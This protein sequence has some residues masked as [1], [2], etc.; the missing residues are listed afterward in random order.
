MV[1]P[2]SKFRHYLHDTNTGRCFVTVAR[3][4]QDIPA[5]RDEAAPAAQSF[6]ETL[7][8]LDDTD[9]HPHTGTSPIHLA[10]DPT[11]T[12]LGNALHNMI[13]KMITSEINRIVEAK[14]KTDMSQV[15]KEALMDMLPTG[16]AAASNGL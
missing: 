9:L 15:A 4:E 8:A 2:K 6:A 10:R 13:Q 14:L 7:Q 5:N 12:T 1:P 3:R 11:G 16:H